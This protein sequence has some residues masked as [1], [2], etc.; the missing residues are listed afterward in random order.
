MVRVN[1]SGGN[2]QFGPENKKPQSRNEQKLSSVFATT[3]EQYEAYLREFNDKIRM[4]NEGRFSYGEACRLY[5]KEHV[6]DKLVELGDSQNLVDLQ[7]H[8]F[9][10]FSLRKNFDENQK[11]T[12]K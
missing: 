9:S 10:V 8:K 5:G 3:D 1:E 2:I 11:R 7:N 6:D 12:S 4:V